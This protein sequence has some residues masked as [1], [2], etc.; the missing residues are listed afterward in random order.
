MSRSFFSCCCG[1]GFLPSDAAGCSLRRVVRFAIG[2]FWL[3]ICPAVMGQ[4]V[5]YQ[6]QPG[7]SFAYRVQITAEEAERIRTW[8]GV[9][10]YEVRSVAED[11]LTITCRGNLAE[12]VKVRRGP[13]GA[14]I[15][16]PLPPAI[17]FPIP[18]FGTGDPEEPMVVIRTNGEIVESRRLENLPY[19]LGYRETLVFEPLGDE[20]GEWSKEKEI[21]V[22]VLERL[23]PVFAPAPMG[24][25]EQVK[26][27]LRAHELA[28]YR[29]AGKTAEGVL[30]ERKYTLRTDQEV[31]GR[32]CFEATG[33]GQ[34]VFDLQLG[35]VRQLKW[36]HWITENEELRSLRSRVEVSAQ[37]LCPEELAELEKRRKEGLEQAK[38]R[39]AQQEKVHPL[40]PGE[41][42][43]LIEELKSRDF[44]RKLRAAERLARAE[45]QEPAEPVCEALLPLLESEQPNLRLMAARALV[46][47]A[48]PI[49]K[50]KLLETLRDRNPLL[51][52]QAMLAIV[53]F[54]SP[55]AAEII[56]DRINE[57]PQARE[58]LKQIGPPAEEAVLREL[59]RMPPGLR[60]SLLDLLGAIG[61]EKS[62]EV[63]DGLL[64][65][66]PIDRPKIEEAIR[67]IQ[68]RLQATPGMPV[69]SSR[70]EMD[71]DG[72]SRA[73]R[74]A[75]KSHRV[76]HRGSLREA[77][78]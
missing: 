33:S 71:N 16:L 1:K 30:I 49:A 63:L 43:V 69:N 56:A 14:P 20:D 26:K 77:G 50:A 68:E 17:R 73:T 31:A 53:P 28:R 23:G 34:I 13:A 66:E 25:G 15:V 29:I 78:N 74:S 2:V 75:G 48:T 8:Q 27:R 60:V 57:L 3:L 65:Q 18:R 61:T 54:A 62:L 7:Q 45:R 47:W 9:L 24:L 67:A 42:E 39:L 35:R 55:E 5:R 58:A 72:E 21:D 22:V 64:K 36:E 44:F 4:S 70:R 10:S 12:T 46:I 11:R 40:E 59:C 37:L 76:A 6:G 52:G 51:A 41:K 19:L 32:P 38:A